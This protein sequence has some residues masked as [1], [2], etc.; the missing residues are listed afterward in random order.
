VDAQG[1]NPDGF[2]RADELKTVF[3]KTST[4]EIGHIMVE[5]RDVDTGGKARCFLRNA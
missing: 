4:Y 2:K 5:K 1:L 3:G